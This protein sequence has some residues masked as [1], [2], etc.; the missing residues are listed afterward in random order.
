M[1]RRVQIGEG[2]D[3]VSLPNGGVYTEDDIA[4]LSDEHYA[5]LDADLFTGDSPVLIDVDAADPILSLVD[6]D[7]AVFADAG[8][9]RIFAVGETSVTVG[10]GDPVVLPA[11]AVV[12]FAAPEGEGLPDIEVT[13]SGTTALVSG[14]PA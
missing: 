13:T 4:V 12:D 6:D 10:D 5:Q 1:T 14:M 9:L 3:Q 7:T 11:T 8:Y 2:H